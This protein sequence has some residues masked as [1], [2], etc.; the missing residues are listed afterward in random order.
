[1]RS[2]AAFTGLKAKHV[3]NKTP[4]VLWIQTVATG[5]L[6]TRALADPA[7]VKNQP[8]LLMMNAKNTAK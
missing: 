6:I 1:M 7:V 4:K 5:M 3:Y 2:E 8:M